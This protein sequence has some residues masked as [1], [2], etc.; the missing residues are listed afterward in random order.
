MNILFL[1]YAFPDMSKSFN[2]YTT[3]VEEF[4]KH[5]HNVFVVAPE[6]NQRKTKISV[7]SGISIL[8]VKTLPVK[9]IPNYLKGISNVVLP[10]LFKRAI[11]KYFKNEKFECIISPTPPIT[12]VSLIAGLKLE[13]GCKFYLILRDIFPQNAVDLGMM[14]KES[15]I[16]NYFRKREKKLYQIADSIGCMSEANINYILKHNSDIS[17]DKLH[18]LPNYQ[19]LFSNLNKSDTHIKTKYGLDNKFVLVFGGNMGKAQQLENVLAL[20]KSCQKYSD[21]IFLLL[22]EGVQKTKLENTILESGISNITVVDSITKTKYQELISAC[23]IGLIS[24]HKD[25]TIPNIPSKTLDYFNVGIPVLASIDKATDYGKILDDAQAGLWSV[26]GDHNSFKNNFDKLYF[27][28]ELRQNMGIN[29][30]NYFEKFLTPEIA[31]E[32]VIRNLIKSD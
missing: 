5:G 8:R 29:G 26:A 18:L 13:Q 14:E 6:A 17:I 12:F 23:D 10:F 19:K 20:A 24:L 21:V 30:R 11:R 3:I 4:H 22:G 7:E 2:M 31:Y 27:N 1:M 15:F 9:N 32:T 16:Y 25:F 28:K